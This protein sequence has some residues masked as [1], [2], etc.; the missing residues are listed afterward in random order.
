MNETLVP[1]TPTGATLNLGTT[2][3][4]DLVPVR[5]VAG[6]SANAGGT[7]ATSPTPSQAPSGSENS[8]G[9]ANSGGFA[10]GGSIPSSGSGAP[11]RNLPKDS[12]NP[13]TKGGAGLPVYKFESKGI[14]YRS[15]VQ[16]NPDGSISISH[17]VTK[18]G[19][20]EL[21]GLSDITRDGQLTNAFYVPKEMQ[22]L[23][24]SK[25]MYA[26]VERVGFKSVVGAYFRDSD[27]YQTF[28]KYYDPQKGNAAEALFQTPAGKVSKT[29]GLKPTNITIGEGKV[30]TIWVKE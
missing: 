25:R 22:Q 27:N 12:D 6:V 14:S 29:L 9:S 24:I 7:K 15:K 19:K 13:P 18:N 11:S 21:A 8:G 5:T 4:V 17:Y 1:K 2:P 30:E 16:K 28:F 20:E 10:S 3:Q 23:E 26:E